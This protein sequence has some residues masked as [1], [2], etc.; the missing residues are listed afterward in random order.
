MIKLVLGSMCILC[1]SV[2]KGTGVLSASEL[3]TLSK[4]DQTS[5]PPV[6]L[7][8]IMLEK[9]VVLCSIQFSVTTSA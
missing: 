8:T 7:D 3:F 2:H 1:A 9:G 6:V 4:V 5:S